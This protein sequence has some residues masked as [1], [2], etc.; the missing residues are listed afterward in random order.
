V[1]VLLAPIAGTARTLPLCVAAS[2]VLSS[3]PNATGAS[4]IVMISVI[5]PVEEFLLTVLTVV[6]DLTGP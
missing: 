2:R 1:I 4:P 6:S 5:A 3:S